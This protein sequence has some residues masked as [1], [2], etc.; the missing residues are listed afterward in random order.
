MFE[1]LANIQWGMVAKGPYEKS[2]ISNIWWIGERFPKVFSKMLLNFKYM[3]MN[4]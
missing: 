1:K 2:Q 4:M 3:S